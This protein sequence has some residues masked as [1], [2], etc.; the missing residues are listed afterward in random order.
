MDIAKFSIKNKLLIYVLTIL[1]IAYGVMTYNKMGKLQDP[2]FTI[3]DAIIITNYTGASAKEVEKEVTN[4]LEETIQKLPYVKR[5][6]AKSQSGQ[7]LIIV[8]MKDK[9]NSKHLPQIWDELRKKIASVEPYLPPRASKPMINDDFGDVYGVMLAVYGDEYSYDELK[10]YVDLLKKE[11]I[12]VDGVGKV[13]TY[14]E[15]QRAI[16]I[17][18]KKDQLAKLGISKQHILKELYI[19]NLVP[20]FGRADIGEELVY[21]RAD[22]NIDSVKDLSNIIIKGADGKSQIFLKDIATIK[23]TYKEPTANILEYD[24]HSAI[25]IGISTISGGNVVAMGEK[26]DAK[27][28]ELDKQKPLGIKIATIAHQAKAVDKAINSF[29][30]SLIQAVAIV[31]AVLLI[32]MGL[33]SG[34]IIGFVLVVTIVGSFIFMP[35]MGI[36]LERISL[37]ALIIALGML[38]DNAIVVVDGILV[39]LQRGMDRVEAAS[40]VIKQTAMPL[41]AATAVAILAF[42][43]IGLS[44]DS[45]GEYTR[46]LFLV[47][48]VSLS[49]SWVT[50]MTLTPI[51]AIK[52]LKVSPNEQK[53][54]YNS[55]IYRLYGG[56]LKF[57]INNRY[58][59]VV[60]AVGVFAVSMY[61]FQFVKQSFFP[62]SS[63]PQILVDHILPQGTSIYTTQKYMKELNKEIESIDGVA[64][65]ST[66]VGSGSL[67]FLL[68]YA[69]EHPNSAYAQMLI[70][71]DDYTKSDAI[72]DK[73]EEI[74]RTKYPS[75]NTFGKKFILGPGEGGKVQVKIFGKDEDKLREY[76]AK[77]IEI[78]RNEPLAKAIRSDWRDRVKV[79]KPIISDE[80]AN[81]NGISRDDIANAILDTYE[82]RTVGVYREA[83]EMIPIILRSPKSEREDIKNLN[84]I[85]IFSPVANKMIPLKQLVDSYETIFEDDIIYR[86]NRKRAITIHADPIGGVLAN[87]VLFKVKDKIDNLEYE[88]GYYV[89]WHGQYKSSR[90]AQKPIAESLPIF[91][92]T[93]FL[94]VLAL[95]NSIKKSLVIW[96]TVPFALIGVVIGL[97]L[98]NKAFGFMSLLG[99]LSLTGMLIKNA[100]VLIDEIVLENEINKRPLAESIY[101]SGLNRLRAVAMAALT[102]ALGM[103]PLLSDVFFSSMAVT[104]IFGLMVATM[105]T[106]ILVPVYYSIFYKS[107]KIK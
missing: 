71:V 47:I 7:S 65:I 38:V 59:I 81:L 21:I 24:G 10:D 105:L 40:E 69:P 92:M 77:I 29:I 88:D 96:L 103:I 102:T 101:S 107:E 82:G 48:L 56:A 67:R 73:I 90:D 57:S 19:K 89:E 3:K 80:K 83:T 51:L 34:L 60:I 95:F 11:L 25:A 93:M 78:F 5:I 106:M 46:S 72:I 49:L 35:P 79:L 84:N 30:E 18:I 8:S 12:L 54:E 15:Q 91:L 45:T 61:S 97:L 99:F 2:E 86:Y 94:I 55:I 70:D 32:F 50:A 22:D 75:I 9:Y 66:F 43:S 36:M 64:H 28:H 14:G 42:G 33:R 63:R 53:E 27:L 31:V 41:F 13:D 23:D 39:R 26:L 104:I 20:N 76:E 68:T 85:Q 98:M 6:R 1:A 74:S 37:G 16:T 100:I 17:E 58:L 62:D 4:R 52:F 44:E 87:D